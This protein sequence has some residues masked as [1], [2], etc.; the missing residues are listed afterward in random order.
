MLLTFF[1]VFVRCADT[2]WAIMSPRIFLSLR[3]LI[4]SS[5][6]FPPGSQIRL[7]HRKPTSFPASL[8]L[9][10]DLWMKNAPSLPY[11]LYVKDTSL[12]L[13]L[14]ISSF[15]LLLSL[16]RL[17]LYGLTTVFSPFICRNTF[18]CIQSSLH[19]WRDCPKF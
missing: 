15:L 3:A 11:S 7:S 18:I 5:K 9:R 8:F 19:L 4:K 2:T 6:P 17:W 10:Y 16:K 14:N 1:F 12:F 13:I